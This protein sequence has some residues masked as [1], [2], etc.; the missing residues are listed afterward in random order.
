MSSLPHTAATH[1]WAPEA[2]LGFR[3]KLPRFYSLFKFSFIVFSRFIVYFHFLCLTIYHLLCYCSQITIISTELSIKAI[4]GQQSGHDCVYI[5]M[6]L[7]LK[8]KLIQY[9][10][11]KHIIAWVRFAECNT[12]H[13][14]RETNRPA[15][16]CSRAPSAGTKNEVM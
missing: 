11:P 15:S 12:L 9:L 2:M 1:A 16:I 8:A 7:L 4:K 14:I 10:E 3:N 6:T 13:V 5:W